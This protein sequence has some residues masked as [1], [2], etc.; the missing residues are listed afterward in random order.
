[1][2]AFDAGRE[3]MEQL[4]I[5]HPHMCSILEVM[6]YELSKSPPPPTPPLLPSLPPQLLW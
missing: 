3:V 5:A 4:K 1:M 2:Q 6:S